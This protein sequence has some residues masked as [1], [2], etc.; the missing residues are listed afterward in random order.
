M[1]A[2]AAEH[3]EAV[4]GLG[5]HHIGYGHSGPA[6]VAAAGQRRRT[7]RGG[8]TACDDEKVPPGCHGLST[9]RR[10]GRFQPTV[11]GTF[12]SSAVSMR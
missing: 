2:R 5:Q 8:D 1:R 9:P 4:P 11:R 12:P 3:H 6:V 7:A 10:L